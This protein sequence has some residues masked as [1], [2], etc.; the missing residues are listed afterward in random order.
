M[1]WKFM[2]FQQCAAWEP[3]Q[4]RSEEVRGGKKPSKSLVKLRFPQVGTVR[5]SVVAGSALVGA[6]GIHSGPCENHWKNKG[7]T[8][9]HPCSQGSP[10]APCGIRWE[11]DRGCQNPSKSLE[12]LMIPAS[13]SRGD[14]SGHM[15]ASR[16]RR[17]NSLRTMQKP[18]ENDGFSLAHR[19][20]QES[21]PLRG[22]SSWN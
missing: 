20:D 8:L 3:G 4:R 19:S 18:L 17:W 9:V 15:E 12:K 11:Q 10:S 22:E 7:S 14:L 16:D 13:G 6:D 21:H 1:T 2:H 5:A